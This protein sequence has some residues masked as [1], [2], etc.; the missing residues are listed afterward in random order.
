MNRSEVETDFAYEEGLFNLR[1]ANDGDIEILAAI[2]ANKIIAKVKQENLD[3]DYERD[4]MHKHEKQEIVHESEEEN[5]HAN[6]KRLRHFIQ[7]LFET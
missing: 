3:D 5:G 1:P 7:C 4:E 6:R 2:P